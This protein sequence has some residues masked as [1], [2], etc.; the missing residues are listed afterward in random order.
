MQQC[1][2]GSRF[3]LAETS[4]RLGPMTPTDL[5]VANDFV[6]R[7]LTL[8]KDRRARLGMKMP[9]AA[10]QVAALRHADPA[11]RRFCL[12]LLDHYA[13]DASTD[14]FRSALQDPVPSVREG[15]LHGLVCERCRK[16]D[17][18]VTDVVSDLIEMLAGDA[19]AEVRHKTIV[20]LSRFNARDSR[21]GEAIARA[22][23]HDP[24]AAIR[25]VARGVAHSGEPHHSNRKAALRN[26][27]RA[28]RERRERGAHISVFSAGD[29]LP[30]TV[31]HEHNA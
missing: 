16:G 14:T 10:M 30:H 9:V 11:L 29:R 15:A 22:A 8:R 3:E 19:N 13:S 7:W 1:A 20:A 25:Y 6:Q 26:V 4:S 28:K 21:A 12:F 18:C 2:G 17:I 31:A 24:D 27:Q 23:H 5:E